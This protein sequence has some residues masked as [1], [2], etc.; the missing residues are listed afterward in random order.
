MGEDCA[1]TAGTDGRQPPAAHRQE[2]ERDDGVDGTEDAVKAAGG[3]ALVHRRGTQSQLAELVEVKHRVLLYGEGRKRPV[4][5]GRGRET[6]HML[7]FLD[8]A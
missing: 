6:G 2:F 8:H 5:P 1:G 3:D 4:R 7:R